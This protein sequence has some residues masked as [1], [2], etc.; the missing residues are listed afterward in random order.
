MTIPF[1]EDK[2]TIISMS[3]CKDEP[4]QPKIFI[5]SAKPQIFEFSLNKNIS[6]IKILN[7]TGLKGEP[8][9]TPLV[10]NKGSEYESLTFTICFLPGNKT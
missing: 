4:G 5:S 7:K 3:F 1:F 10:I 6:L 9:G 8:C 2:S